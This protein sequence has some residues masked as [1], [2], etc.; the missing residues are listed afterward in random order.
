MKIDLLITADAVQVANEKL[1]VLGG[2][3]RYVYV[4]KF[5]VEHN[6]GVAL[7]ILVPW[8]Q[9]NVRHSVEVVLVDADSNSVLD[10][11]VVQGEFETGRPPGIRPGSAQRVLMA[12]NFRAP[13]SKSG[14]YQIIARLDGHDESSAIFE[15]VPISPA[16]Q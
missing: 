9:T 12:V 16:K 8:E 5:P 13:L 6:M 1:Y 4:Q 11:P 3:W 7:G 14:E 15:A 10:S 2:G